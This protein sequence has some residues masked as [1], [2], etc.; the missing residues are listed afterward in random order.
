MFE[1]PAQLTNKEATATLS[2]LQAALGAGGAAG[3]V[4]EIDAARLERFDT[5]ALAVILAARRA[6]E[7]GGR[8]VRLVNMPAQM[9]GLA[10]LYGVLPLVDGAG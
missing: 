6:A 8:R 7:T 2:A 10:R 1:L 4:F 9:Q 3:E 5:S